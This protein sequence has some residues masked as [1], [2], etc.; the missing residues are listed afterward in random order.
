MF[1]CYLQLI[2]QQLLKFSH[3][4]P[5]LKQVPSIK[6]KRIRPIFYNTAYFMRMQLVL[7]NHL[8]GVELITIL[9]KS[10]L[11]YMSH[12]YLAIL[13][14]L[15][16]NS[17]QELQQQSHQL[18]LDISVCFVG[19]LLLLFIEIQEGLYHD[20]ESESNMGF[21]EGRLAEKYPVIIYKPISVT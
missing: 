21:Q 11:I 1:C 15:Q 4:S 10:C 2:Q 13:I 18:T 3:N 7:S 5:E 6:M 17:C 12:L 20:P 14:L 19:F 9:I 16:K 8:F